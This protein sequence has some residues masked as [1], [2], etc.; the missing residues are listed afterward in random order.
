[1]LRN[2]LNLLTACLLVSLPLI[3]SEGVVAERL[4]RCSSVN[5][6]AV[7]PSGDS[8]TA[9]ARASK[10][11]GFP[12]ESWKDESEFDHG[13]PDERAKVREVLFRTARP[14]EDLLDVLRH[15]KGTTVGEYLRRLQSFCAFTVPTSRLS[16]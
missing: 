12:P 2:Q 14:L 13:F 4:P 5:R 15:S 9:P 1:M 6:P 7:K 16:S 8:A 3:A 10:A 11:P